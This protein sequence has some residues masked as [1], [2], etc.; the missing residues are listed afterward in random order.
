MQPSSDREATSGAL[1][2]DEHTFEELL[3]IVAQGHDELV[4]RVWDAQVLDVSGDVASGKVILPSFDIN[5]HLAR[6]AD[7]WMIAN[8]LYRTRDDP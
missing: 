7:R 3:E 6:F 5:L 8:T 4:E 2:L 1:D